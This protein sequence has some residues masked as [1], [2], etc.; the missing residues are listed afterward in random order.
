[1]VNE[2]A[3]IG[4]RAVATAAAREEVYKRYDAALR[5]EEVSA[6]PVCVT[7]IRGHA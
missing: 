3:P 7:Y 4:K 1:M 5:E 2:F 6:D